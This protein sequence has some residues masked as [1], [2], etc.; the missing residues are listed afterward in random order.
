MAASSI[1]IQLAEA[2]VLE[3]ATA[4]AANEW[5]PAFTPVRQWRPV[6]TRD[7]LAQKGLQVSVVPV[8][9]PPL[10]L[11]TRQKRQYDYGV[12]IDFQTVVDATTLEGLDALV[13]LVDGDVTAFYSDMHYIAGM[14]GW[15]VKELGLLDDSIY[16]IDRLYGEGIFEAALALTIRGYQ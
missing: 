14:T 5:T 1:A 9:R 3:L 11:F 16:S 10:D 15:Y 7:E 12:V 4:A 6:Y 2:I 13:N 8:T